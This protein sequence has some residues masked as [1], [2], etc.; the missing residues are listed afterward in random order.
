MCIG[1]YI[2]RYMYIYCGNSIQIAKKKLNQS[3]PQTIILHCVLP[4]AGCSGTIVSVMGHGR[5]RV[6]TR[7]RV[8]VRAERTKK[9]RT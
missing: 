7:G 3:L 2:Y 1:I 6:M 9:P 8:A 4:L 5:S